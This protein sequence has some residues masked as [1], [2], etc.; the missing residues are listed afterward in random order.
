VRRVWVGIVLMVAVRPWLWI[1]VVR[2]EAL[3]CVAE[4]LVVVVFKVVAKLVRCEMRL[5]QARQ[6]PLACEGVQASL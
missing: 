1:L 5:K 6:D 4:R 3:W 2:D